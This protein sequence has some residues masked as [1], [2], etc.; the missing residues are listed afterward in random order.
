MIFQKF[1]TSSTKYYFSLYDWCLVYFSTVYFVDSICYYLNLDRIVLKGVLR[2]SDYFLIKETTYRY[3]P[4]SIL[5]VVGQWPNI[6]TLFP[7]NRTDNF[8]CSGSLRGSLSAME[9][10]TRTTLFSLFFP[11]LIFIPLYMLDC[12]HCIWLI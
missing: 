4:D 2:S 11:S 3:K 12:F 9:V 1:F 5:D 6:C 7:F 8:Y 10:W